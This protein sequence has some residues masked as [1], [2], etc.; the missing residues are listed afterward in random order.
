MIYAVVIRDMYQSNDWM[1]WTFSSICWICGIT[2]SQTNRLE[3]SGIMNDCIV[4]KDL[5]TMAPLEKTTQS[6]TTTQTT[7]EEQDTTVVEEPITETTSSIRK[8]ARTVT[9]SPWITGT[10]RRISKMDF[11]AWCS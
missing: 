1:P 7:P 4:C 9:T 3:S 10:M 6:T 8:T 5:P 2:Q 11:T